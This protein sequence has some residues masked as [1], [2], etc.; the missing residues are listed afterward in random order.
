MLTM[1]ATMTICYNLVMQRKNDDDE[2]EEEEHGKLVS[3]VL[4]MCKPYFGS[5]QVINMDNYYTSPEV[6]CCGA[7][8]K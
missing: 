8:Q 7:F 5:G 2:P 1:T 6:G 4:D 3:L